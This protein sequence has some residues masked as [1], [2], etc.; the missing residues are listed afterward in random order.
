MKQVWTLS[1]CFEHFGAARCRRHFGGS[2]VSH[3][4][5]TVVVAMWEDEIVREDSR[6]TYRSR[7]GP[8][9]KGKSQRVSMQWITNLKWAITRC[10][11]CVRVVVL[12]A[13]ETQANPRVIRSCYPDDALTMQITHFD[14]KTGTFQA[15][16][17]SPSASSQH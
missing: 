7:F 15:C 17:V 4:G 9:L 8:A 6:A 2:A 3:D 1:T 14:S 5:R 10:K 13:E 16:T 11:G 12:T